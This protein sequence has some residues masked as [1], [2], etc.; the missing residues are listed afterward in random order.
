[1]NN[2]LDDLY[3]SL[4]DPEYATLYLD[5]AES[6]AERE[7][8]HRDVATAQQDLRN[9]QISEQLETHESAA[10]IM[11]DHQIA[12]RLREILTAYRETPDWD[13][14]EYL[15][16]EDQAIQRIIKLF[17]GVTLPPTPRS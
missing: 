16:A 12:T 15:R 3:Q 9:R 1:M 11:A 17:F 10:T 2:Y 13:T 7:L 8:A 5:S 4:A 6:L 14:T